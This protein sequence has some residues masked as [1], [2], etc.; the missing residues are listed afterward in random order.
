MKRWIYAPNLGKTRHIARDGGVPLCNQPGDYVERR[1]SR[2]P[3]CQNCQSAWPGYNR[4]QLARV[5]LKPV[6]KRE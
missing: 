4:R 2:L 6:E 1:K 3:E 5:G